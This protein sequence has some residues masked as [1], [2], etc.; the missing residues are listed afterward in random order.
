[1]AMTRYNPAI[2]NA[3]LGSI[4]KL[5][6]R[7]PNRQAAAGRAAPRQGDPTTSQVLG[8]D[9]RALLRA[10]AQQEAPLRRTPSNPAGNS[11]WRSMAR[12]RGEQL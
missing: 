12:T 10:A 6:T 4:V 1:M 2:V 3:L 11:I 5:T 9:C 7:S 8:R